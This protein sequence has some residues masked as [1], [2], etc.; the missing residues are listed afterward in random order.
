[1]NSM[2]TTLPSPLVEKRVLFFSARKSL[3]GRRAY[4]DSI[5]TKQKQGVVM[6]PMT[7]AA[8]EEVTTPS[9]TNKELL[10]IAFTVSAC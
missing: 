2:R 10:E 7:A 8:L 3:I 4:S 6:R 5:Y 9:P 1:M